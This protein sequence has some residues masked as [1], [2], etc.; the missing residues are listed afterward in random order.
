MCLNLLENSGSVQVSTAISLPLPYLLIVCSQPRRCLQSL[1]CSTM[2]VNLHITLIGNLIELQQNSEFLNI[3]VFYAICNF[4]RTF[5]C[6]K[7]SFTDSSPPCQ[8]ITY[9]GRSIIYLPKQERRQWAD[10]N[11]SVLVGTCLEVSH[12]QPQLSAILT[13]RV[14]TCQV[15]LRVSSQQACCSFMTTRQ[16]SC[17]QNLKLPFSNVGSSS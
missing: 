16:C 8:R 14:T 2:A 6:I 13:V 5:L 4:R 3:T 15:S 9:E 17:L 7:H 11:K 10:W 1:S 12:M